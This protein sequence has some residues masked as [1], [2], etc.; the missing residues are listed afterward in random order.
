MSDAPP[1]EDS[2]VGCFAEGAEG[3]LMQCVVEGT[4]AA[5]PSPALVGLLL[6]GVL[7]TSLYVAGDGTVAVPAVV[8]IVFGGLM[9]PLLP[10][11]FVTLAYSV[12]TVGIMAAVFAVWN[13]FTSQGGF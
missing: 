3:D 5:G 2:S 4:F 1:L 7:L 8:T 12:A 10:A 13:R 6:S 9:V 11:Q